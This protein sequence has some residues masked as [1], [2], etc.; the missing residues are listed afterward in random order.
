[1]DFLIESER[2]LIRPWTEDDRPAITRF[3]TD[4]QMM[5]YISDGQPWDEARIEDFLQRQATGLTGPGTCFGA[6]VDRAT[7]QIIGV[8]G[9]QYLRPGVGELGWW[10]ARERWGHG[11]ASEGA[12]ASLNYAVEHLQLRRLLAVAHPDN[13]ASLRVM[14]KIGMHSLGIMRSGDINPRYGDEPGAVYEYL[15]D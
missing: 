4:P 1:M 3:V 11:L 5:R 7:G 15:A 14:E 8:S 12:Q 2:L 9:V 6:A 13:L 10:I